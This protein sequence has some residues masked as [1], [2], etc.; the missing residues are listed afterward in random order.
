[1]PFNCIL[2]IVASGA[3]DLDG[4]LSLEGSGL[5]ACRPET[6]CRLLWSASTEDILFCSRSDAGTVGH[7]RM[8]LKGSSR[9]TQSSLLEAETEGLL[10]SQP[11]ET[12]SGTFCAVWTD[13]PL[14]SK[15]WDPGSNADM[16]LPSTVPARLA[17]L[18]KRWDSRSWSFVW[19]EL[20]A[21]IYR[22]HHT[23]SQISLTNDTKW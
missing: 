9:L 5:A 18:L 12:V 21:A 8:G 3:T 19:S 11:L 10:G 14:L 4:T 13:D 23:G 2:P 16:L 20:L 6:T 22:R 1:M 17:R 7:C 15:P